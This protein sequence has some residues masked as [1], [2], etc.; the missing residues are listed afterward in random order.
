MPN[1][2]SPDDDGKNDFFTPFADIAS[3]PTV[4]LLRIYDRSGGLVFEKKH[5]KPNIEPDGWNGY[6]AN[7]GKKVANGVY[8]FYCQIGFAN[9]SRLVKTGTV[10]AAGSDF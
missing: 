9:G 2:F 4:E 1:V 6:W 3:E 8:I 7:T 10:T 5:F